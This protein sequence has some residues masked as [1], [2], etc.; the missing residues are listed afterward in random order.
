MFAHQLYVAER[1]MQQDAACNSASITIGK[2]SQKY[3]THRYTIVL[4]PIGIEPIT[5]FN[6]SGISPYYV[7]DNV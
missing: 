4:A 7:V 3:R 5:V 1:R 6:A 2:W